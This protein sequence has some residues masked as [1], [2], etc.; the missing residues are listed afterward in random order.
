MCRR[1]AGPS[2]KPQLGTTYTQRPSA[3]PIDS[4]TASPWNTWGCSQASDFR[5]RTKGEAAQHVE[6]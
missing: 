4:D 5:V 6:S 1:N 3:A 2:A